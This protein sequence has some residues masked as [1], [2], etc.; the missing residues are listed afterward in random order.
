[1]AITASRRRLYEALVEEMPWYVSAVVR[2][3]MAIADQLEMPV[4]DVH[5]VAALL[6]FG[7]VGVRR[8][9]ELMGMTTGAATR[10]VDRLERGGFVRRE[11]DPDDRRR[12]V[13]H[14][15]PERVQVIARYYD[16]IG[17]RFRRRLSNYS[18]D[19]LRFLLE[20]LRAGR[21]D[22]EAETTRLRT[23]GRRHGVRQR[24]E[25]QGES[26]ILH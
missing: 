25:S 16:S 12:L 21:A 2:F 15:V 11:P 1:V 23:E 14:V 6:E 24:R 3:Q 18:D 13:L 20:F 9:A 17:E 19:D 22:S 10:L 7:P 26:L 5:A 4:A 8:L